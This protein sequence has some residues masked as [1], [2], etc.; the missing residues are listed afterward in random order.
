MAPH[1]S[2]I[3]FLIQR[4][5][6]AGSTRTAPPPPCSR[7]PTSSVFSPSFSP[8]LN[9]FFLSR[10]MHNDFAPRS[11]PRR[12]RRR[13]F[14]CRC[15]A[16]QRLKKAAFWGMWGVLLLVFLIQWGTMFTFL[17]GTGVGFSPPATDLH[18]R[19]KLQ[20]YWGPGYGPQPQRHFCRHSRILLSTDR[21]RAWNLEFPR[22]RDL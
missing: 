22:Q 9:M 3:G 15:E 12:R 5:W 14:R 1:A 7:S 21:T 17:I 18:H 4:T 6:N 11:R 16:A 8:T 20:R 13:H 2:R 19:R 10:D